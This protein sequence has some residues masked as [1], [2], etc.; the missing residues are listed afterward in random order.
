MEF[1]DNTR[2]TLITRGLAEMSRLGVAM[3]GDPMTFAGLAGM[4]DLVVT[5]ISPFSR[6]RH[7]GE[8]LGRG[9][10]LDDVLGGMSMVAEGVRTAVTVHELAERHGVEMPVCHEIYRIVRGEMPAA[11]AYRGLRRQPGHENDPG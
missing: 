4:G 10:S 3:G 9:E 1:G 11:E 5:C 7:V 8:Q 2:A 6:N